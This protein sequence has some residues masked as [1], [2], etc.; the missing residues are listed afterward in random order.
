[1]DRRPKSPSEIL[2]EALNRAT[3]EKSISKR[4]DER[5][6]ENPLAGFLTKRP[7]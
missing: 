2:Q 3:A 7:K 6:D 5:D 1:M 4:L